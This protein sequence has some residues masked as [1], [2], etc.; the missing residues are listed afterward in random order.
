MAK[1][2]EHVKRPMNAF[3]VWSRGQRR[4]VAREHPERPNSEMGKRPGAEWK[5]LGHAEKRPYMD[6]AER[7]R[8]RHLREHPDYKYGPRRK[9]RAEAPAGSLRF[10]AEEATLAT[11]TKATGWTKGPPSRR[12]TS[13]GWPSSSGRPSGGG[14]LAWSPARLCPQVPA[15][16]LLPAAAWASK[17]AAGWR[18]TRRR[19]PAPER[20]ATSCGL[21]GATADISSGKLPLS[22]NILEIAFT[23][24]LI[25]KGL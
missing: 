16:I 7:L 18:R 24:L 14:G 23:T 15:Y 8:D 22:K 17:S 6:E 19:V 21:A 2:P 3:M 1:D 12:L 10:L 4:Q 25:Q 9:V 11:W 13:V 20:N 5:K